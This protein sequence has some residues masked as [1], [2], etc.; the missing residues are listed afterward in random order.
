MEVTAS[1]MSELARRLLAGERTGVPT[2]T[3]F[4]DMVTGSLL[5][6][7]QLRGDWRA[8]HRKPNPSGNGFCALLSGRLR[9]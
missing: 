3:E 4:L 5:P 7:D 1:I 8:Y 2:A 6:S 9:D